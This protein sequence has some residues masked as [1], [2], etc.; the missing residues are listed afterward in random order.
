MN[1]GKGKGFCKSS[2]VVFS[3][4]ILV[5]LIALALSASAMTLT[6]Q[7]TTWSLNTL[8]NISL[9]AVGTESI[10]ENVTNVAIFASSSST[11]NSSKS[12]LINLKNP[13]EKTF[14]DRARKNFLLETIS[15]RWG[16][17][18]YCHIRN[19]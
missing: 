1:K 12:K 15:S 5:M 4:S 19:I 9:D 11:A 14:M 6:L 13:S 16:R 3:L 18:E 2:R 10:G 7:T 8:V 17:W